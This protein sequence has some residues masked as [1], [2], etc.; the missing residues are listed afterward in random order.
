[1][2]QEELEIGRA[3]PCKGHGKDF[4]FSY[5]QWGTTEGYELGEYF[6]SRFVF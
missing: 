3:R 2:V 5:V 4:V 6:E 1:M